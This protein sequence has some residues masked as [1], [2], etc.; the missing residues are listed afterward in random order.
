MYMCVC[1]ER[2]CAAYR[3]VCPCVYVSVASC[4]NMRTWTFVTQRDSS[5]TSSRQ[6]WLPQI[7]SGLRLQA[8]GVSEPNNGTDTLSLETRAVA[9]PYVQTQQRCDDSHNRLNHHAN[10]KLNPN[11]QLCGVIV[12]VFDGGGN[13]MMSQQA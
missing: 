1:G 13:V 5:F 3:L 7:A 11:P 10:S 2:V 6:T 8:F 9:S 12:E 4:I